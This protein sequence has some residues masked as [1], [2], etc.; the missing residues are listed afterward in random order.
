M[1]KQNY[2]FIIPVFMFIVSGCA[3]NQ[4]RIGEGAAIGGILGAGVG[5]IVGHQSGHDV[6]GVL[7][8][9]AIGAAS[10]AAVGSQIQK[11]PPAQNAPQRASS[12]SSVPAAQ[13]S[14]QRVVDL[15]QEGVAS[16]DIIAR[17]KAADNPKYYLTA[18]DIDY[19]HKKGVSQRVIDTMQSYK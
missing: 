17:I 10:G 5:E 15:S 13:L 9:G 8:G 16:D 2:F 14:V 19:M 12:P 1:R 6:T 3:E 11:Q 18:D 7:L 4:T